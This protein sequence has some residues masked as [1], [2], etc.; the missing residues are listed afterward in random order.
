MISATEPISVLI[1]DDAP[2]DRS[3]VERSLKR[4]LP[5]IDVRTAV[6]RDDLHIMLD[7][8]HFDVIVSDYMIR[9][10]TGL[11]VISDVRERGLDT[12]IVILTGTGTEQVAI[13]AMKRGVAD[14]VI[15]NA[16]HIKRLPTTVLRVIQ[17]HRLEK[18]VTQLEL[19]IQQS[20]KL[21]AVG[22]VS[23]GVA[24]DFNNLLA[25]ILNHVAL[26]ERHTS[27]S[28]DITKSL[29]AVKEASEQAADLSRNLL[30]FSKRQ[31]AHYKPV[32]LCA[33]V[34]QIG[35][36]L[37]RIL[38]SN[39]HITFVLADEPVWVLGNRVQLQQTV[40]NLA[41]NAMDA[42]PEGGSLRIRVKAHKE[43]E[44]PERALI[45][46]TDTGHGMPED[47]LEHVFDPFFT[48]KGYEKRTGLG[49]TMIK[50]MIEEHQGTIRVQSEVG[51]GTECTMELP[52]LD[53]H[54]AEAMPSESD[55]L[56]KQ[57]KD[58][59]VLVVASNQQV[60]AVL[61]GELLSLGL[62]AIQMIDVDAAINHLAQ[63]P[64]E[65]DIILIDHDMPELDGFNGA[66][67]IRESGSK[68]PIILMNNPDEKPN[69]LDLTSDVINYIKPFE[70]QNLGQF[71][72]SKLGI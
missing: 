58:K 56:A 67:K 28:P 5:N 16:H 51:Q 50:R 66:Q 19:E 70:V 63:H 22:L 6:T 62:Q 34:N 39:I 12:P 72:C 49:L 42:M 55:V 30:T 23:A 3:L 54:D 53:R 13:E 15:K 26:M 27:T 57:N 11:D 64:D 48:T 1:I 10:F 14:Y 61:A 47:V 60:N 69:D 37:N 9:G 44:G 33:A 7:K 46:I 36:L 8:R 2:A 43:A 17:S 29:A 68:V 65:I 41:I 31:P 35:V 18:D 25:I 21:E 59:C 71:I 24:H 45:K 40:L 32:D 20:Q 4:E 52:C 38:P